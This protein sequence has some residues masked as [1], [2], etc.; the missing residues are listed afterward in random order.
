R[1]PRVDAGT[2]PLSPNPVC[3]LEGI[4]RL[5]RRYVETSRAAAFMPG[6]FVLDCIS[7]RPLSYMTSSKL[8]EPRDYIS[9]RPRRT[10]EL[11]GVIPRGNI[12]CARVGARY[13]F[14]AGRARYEG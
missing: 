10:D 3:D 1:A 7:A 9:C 6:C 12:F 4:D 13:A 5:N 14:F 2:T 8:S 11:L